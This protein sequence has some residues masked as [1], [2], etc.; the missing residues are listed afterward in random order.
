M[1]RKPKDK[2]EQPDE[3]TQA[4]NAPARPFHNDTLHPALVRL[5]APEA[6]DWKAKIAKRRKAGK[7]LIKDEAELMEL[8]K[9]YLVTLHK[10]PLREARPT[11]D[12]DSFLTMKHKPA[13]VVGL[14]AFAGF[15]RRVWYLWRDD[16]SD[17][18]RPDLVD[19]MERITDEFYAAMMEQGATGEIAPGFTA[20]FLGIGDKTEISLKGDSKAAGDRV[21]Q[22]VMAAIGALEDGS[23]KEPEET[24]EEG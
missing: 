9:D 18:Y 1:A 13:T 16:T 3:A 23:V 6:V 4:A 20:R 24:A 2:P 5:M 11:G 15:S 22:D 17:K 12:G 21:E 8:V 19:A 7:P 14:C 10:S